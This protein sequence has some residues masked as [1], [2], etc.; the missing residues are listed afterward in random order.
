MPQTLSCNLFIYKLLEVHWGEPGS[1]GFFQK[2][3]FSLWGGG[4]R[5]MTSDGHPFINFY[6]H[7]VHE[8]K[9]FFFS[10]LFLSFSYLLFL[11]SSHNLFQSSVFFLP[12]FFLCISWS[13][14]LFI[15]SSLHPSLFSC[16]IPP[17]MSS[18]PR[19]CT[20][21]YLGGGVNK[22]CYPPIKFK[23]LFSKRGSDGF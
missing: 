12:L 5:L 8:H 2:R 22:K 13:H 23:L 21:F 7:M 17:F 19:A 10:S 16:Q 6:A 11:S 18:T 14:T 1:F 15:P 20:G 9:T 4:C 3:N